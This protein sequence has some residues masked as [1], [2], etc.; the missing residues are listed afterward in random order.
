VLILRDFLVGV[1]VRGVFTIF[2][3]LI[4]GVFMSLYVKLIEE[5]ELEE[6]YGEEY[7][8]YKEKTPFLI[9]RKPRF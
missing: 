9:P 1:L 5:K 6:S 7:R 8:K 3:A 4:I 2:C